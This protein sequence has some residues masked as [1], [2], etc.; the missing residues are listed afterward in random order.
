MADK[1]PFL[2]SCI[3]FYLSIGAA[4]FQILEEPNWKSARDK[5]TLQK[6]NILKSHPC[7]TKQDLEEILEVW[8]PPVCFNNS[9]GVI[10][11]APNSAVGRLGLIKT[12]TSLARLEM[13]TR[14]GLRFNLNLCGG[15]EVGWTYMSGQLRTCFSCCP[16]RD[17]HQPGWRS[18]WKHVKCPLFFSI[19]AP[20]CITASWQKVLGFVRAERDGAS[21]L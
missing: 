19:D 4:I 7:L 14:V 10:V 18:K 13:Q 11:C 21:L 2:T 15:G 6:E 3:I 16:G 1:G 8:I 17:Q 20:Y 9:V 12:D 5:Y